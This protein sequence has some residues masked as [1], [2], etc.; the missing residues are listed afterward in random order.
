MIDKSETK[1]LPTFIG[2]EV[3]YYFICP[4]KEVE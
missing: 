1:H 3:G 2:T 4:K